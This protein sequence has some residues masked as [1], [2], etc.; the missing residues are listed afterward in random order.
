M[1]AAEGLQ[2]GAEPDADPGRSR[3]AA[4]SMVTPQAADWM[5]EAGKG[6][7]QLYC[8]GWSPFAG[9]FGW[10]GMLFWWAPMGMAVWPESGK[11]GIDL[12]S[13]LVNEVSRVDLTVYGGAGAGHCAPAQGGATGTPR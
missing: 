7:L 9:S 3:A 13:M 2:V 10:A 6:L 5:Y 11:I 8:V 1:L 4:A 12:S